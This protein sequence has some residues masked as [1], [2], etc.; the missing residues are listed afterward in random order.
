MAVYRLFGVTASILV[1][2][3]PCS[4]VARCVPY[5]LYIRG[6][7]AHAA[8]GVVLQRL[9][10]GP[11][12]VGAFHVQAHGGPHGA[13]SVCTMTYVLQFISRYSYRWRY[14]HHGISSSIIRPETRSRILLKVRCGGCTE[15]LR[16]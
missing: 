13:I 12:R 1:T 4:L 8:C 15:I 11:D 7:G 6:H 3:A 16:R 14:E 9:P 5:S 2:N 10:D